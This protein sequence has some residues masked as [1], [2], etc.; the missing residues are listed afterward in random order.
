MESDEELSDRFI[1]QLREIA[2]SYPGKTVLVTT[3]GGCVRTFL[4]RAVPSEYEKWSKGT[5]PNAGYVKALSDGVDFF[6][7]EVVA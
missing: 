1:V 4:M 2:V 3:H 6:V 5:F 7:K